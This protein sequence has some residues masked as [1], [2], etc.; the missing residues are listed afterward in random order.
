MRK[1]RTYV[2]TAAFLLAFA[3]AAVASTIYPMNMVASD[4][5]IAVDPKGFGRGYSFTVDSDNVWVTDFAW[6]TPS[7]ASFSYDI[8]LWDLGS[9]A[10]L[11][12]VT[13][14]SGSDTIWSSIAI[15]PVSLLNGG[16]YAITLY[17]EFGKLFWSGYSQHI[18]DSDDITFT[19][20]QLCYA[21]ASVEFPYANLQD[22]N[23]GFVDF[24][25]QIGE[26]PP[27]PVPLPAGLPMLAFGLGAI[28]LLKRA[29]WIKERP[30]QPA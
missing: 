20:A 8:A 2:A 13:G 15:S 28:A 22:Y 30:L 16:S 18:P 6:N 1:T 9:M 24:G 27:S 29:Q 26:P 10:Q 23:Y 4:S 12:V 5:A 7:D 21:C 19:G 3:P 17:S 25:Y 11:A 14:L